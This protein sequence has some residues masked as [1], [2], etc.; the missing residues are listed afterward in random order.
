MEQ[1]F[2]LPSDKQ[3]DQFDIIVDALFKSGYAI[4]PNA[5]SESWTDKLFFHLKTIS[6]ASFKKAGIGRGQD[7][8]VNQF[9]RTDEIAWIDQTDAS[10]RPYLTWIEELRLRI[11]QQLFLGLFDYECHFAHYPRGSFYKRHYDAFKGCETKRVVTT[12]L[13]LNPLWEVDNGGELILYRENSLEVLEKISPHYAKLVVFLSEKFPHEVLT[14]QRDRYSLTGWFKTN[15][16]E[17]P[18]ISM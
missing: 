14:T 11:N 1:L 15:T 12:I 9:I 6:E 7:Y 17:S 2:A 5:F 8:Q 3:P 4:L 13:Y 10:L 16:S 18:L